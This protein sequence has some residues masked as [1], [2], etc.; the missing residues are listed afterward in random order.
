[1]VAV[2]VM[3]A[4]ALSVAESSNPLIGEKGLTKILFEVVS[5]F[6][7]VGLSLGITPYLSVLGKLI[8]CV[9]MFVG[10]LGPVVIAIVI[11]RQVAQP[12]VIYP[13]EPIMIG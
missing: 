13:E 10:R 2:I 6:G 8:V 12:P 3:M 4:L 9:T 7:T 1:M 11:A 5:A